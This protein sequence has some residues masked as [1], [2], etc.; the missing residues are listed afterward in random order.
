MTSLRV[1]L[2]R[3]ALLQRLMDLIIM[4]KFV[5][6]VLSITILTIQA[7]LLRVITIV[8]MVLLFLDMNM[9]IINILLNYR[10]QNQI[11]LIALSRQTI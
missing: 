4:Q 2:L 3:K 10:L 1:L 5:L 9:D 11:V 8:K 6:Q 7:L